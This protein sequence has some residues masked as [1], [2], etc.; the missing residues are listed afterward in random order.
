MNTEFKFNEFVNKFYKEPKSITN[1]EIT[2]FK[3]YW[4]GEVI[5]NSVIEDIQI[6][7]NIQGILDTIVV[8]SSSSQLHKNCNE[9]I[10]DLLTR[11]EN[12]FYKINPYEQLA[13]SIVKIDLHLKVSKE[14]LK[15]LPLEFLA[16]NPQILT[17]IKNLYN[18]NITTVQR[19]IVQIYKDEPKKA[20]EH[21]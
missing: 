4:K 2:E 21:D 6:T 18:N 15:K 3:K 14:S 8:Y 12:K 7:N 17:E 13:F 9:L 11:K 10:I 1:E 20:K 19:S 5:G 16:K